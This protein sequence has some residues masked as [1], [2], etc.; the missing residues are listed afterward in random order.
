M[1]RRRLIDLGEGREVVVNRFGDTVTLTVGRRLEGLM[2][3]QAIELAGV[4][5]EAAAVVVVPTPAEAP[6]EP[7][8]RLLH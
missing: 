7:G 3:E 8:R 1:A 5:L 6:E 4:L 2:P